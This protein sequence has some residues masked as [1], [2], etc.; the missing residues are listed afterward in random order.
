MA[1]SYQ[2]R[3]PPTSAQQAPEAEPEK[4]A[5]AT[6][7]D[8]EWDYALTAGNAA[9]LAL[10]A[11]GVVTD[12]ETASSLLHGADEEAPAAKAAETADVAPAA[13]TAETGDVTAVTPA[14]PAAPA[15]TNPGGVYAKPFAKHERQTEAAKVTLTASQKNELAVFQ[16][17]WAANK[18]RY[19][20]VAAK[21]NV[22]A[23]LI[24]AIHYRES[25]MNFNTY[26]HQGDPLG[27]KAVHVPKNIPIFYDWE[28]AAVHA[29]NMK[30][31]LRDN[32]NMTADTTD[33]V[34]LASYAEAYNGLGYYN[35]GKSSPYVYAGT[36]QYD[37]GMYVADGKFS[38]DAKDRRLGVI[39]LTRGVDSEGSTDVHADVA[40]ERRTPDQIWGAVL[41]GHILRRGQNGA[42]VKELQKRL[43]AA[44]HTVGVDGDFGP[45]T[46]KAVKAFQKAN[47]LEE[48]GVVGVDTAAAI[49]RGAPAK[50][51]A[52]VSE[53]TTEPAAPTTEA[54]TTEPAAPAQAPAPPE[55][56]RVLAG[57]LTVQRRASGAVVEF[58]QKLLVKAGFTIDVDGSFGPATDQALRAYQKANG[59]RA[60]G[61]VGSKTATSFG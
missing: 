53:T 42:E 18:A 11:D 17:N 59:L 2:Q 38:R 54:P 28:E 52:P 48:D 39:A 8:P 49:D 22:P 33:E 40:S 30:K 37:G 13:E 26:L 31:G 24:A 29:L 12:D 3:P 9:V 16:K 47:G 50:T 15:T 27:K 55:W 57:R 7:G 58:L 20:R 6:T 60:D 44:G 10:I 19:Q 41:S 25:S 46:E 36:D 1:A 23:E 14:A 56:A 51:E 4:K 43:L 35:R 34:A 45:G 61:I 21:T 32:L 5:A